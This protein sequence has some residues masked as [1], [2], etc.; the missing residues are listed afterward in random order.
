MNGKLVNVQRKADK[1]YTFADGTHIPAGKLV[2][3]SQ[4]EI[5]RD[6]SYYLFPETFNPNR[7]MTYSEDEATTKFADVNWTYLY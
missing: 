2:A 6:S 5:M 7:F 3:I 1:T 4:R